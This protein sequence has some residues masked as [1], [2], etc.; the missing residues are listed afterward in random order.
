M[1]EGSDTKQ[2][3]VDEHI[4]SLFATPPGSE[5]HLTKTL[6]YKQGRIILQDKAS[7]FPAYLLFSAPYIGAAP[8]T[9][10]FNDTAERLQQTGDIIDACAAPGNKTTHLAALAMNAHAKSGSTDTASDKKPSITAV[11]RDKTRAVTLAQ[12]VKTA[13]ADEDGLVTCLQGQDFSRLNPEDKKWA[14]VTALLLDPSCSGSGIVG[15]DQGDDET[16]E[17]GSKLVL[18]LPVA[19]RPSAAVAGLKHKKKTMNGNKSESKVT[20]LNHSNN[21]EAEPSADADAAGQA[22]A[23]L[24][25]RLHGLQG[26]QLSLL[27]HA[28]RFPAAQKVVYSTCSVHA[29][30]NEQVVYRALNSKIAKDRSWRIMT[31]VEQIDGMRRWHVR[32]DAE[33]FQHLCPSAAETGGKG[34]LDPNVLADA[35]IRCEKGTADGTMGFFAVGFVRSDPDHD[36][37]Q[38]GNGDE[39]GSHAVDNIAEEEEDSFE[40]FDD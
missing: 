16:P 8:T 38:Q 27:T 36:M 32:G 6:A 21:V 10:S 26:F 9:T 11:E 24:Q 22:N 28:F 19:S 1:L 25:K 13:G 40:G 39:H 14:S 2:Y 37:L 3:Y 33:A 18:P 29:E 31:R 7:C 17:G 34:I 4:P 23:E 30:E 5:A 20:N 15:R 35:C 12:M